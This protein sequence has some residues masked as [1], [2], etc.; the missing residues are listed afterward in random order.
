MFRILSVLFATLWLVSCSQPKPLNVGVHP[1]IGYQPIIIAQQKNR[2]PEHIALLNNQTALDTKQQFL[3][4]RI[5]AGYLT[6]DEMLQLNEQGLHLT[7]VLVTNIS[8]GA[9]KVIAR[10]PA[11]TRTTLKGQ[12]IGYEKGTVGELM[13]HSFLNHMQLTLEE[14]VPQA[15]SMDKQIQAWRNHEIDYLISYDPIAN[16]IINQHGGHKVFSSQQIP[17]TIIDVLAAR[18]SLIDQDLDSVKALTAA[19]FQGLELIKHDFQETSYLM[20]DNLGI[21]QQEVISTMG[22]LTLPSQAINREMLSNGFFEKTQHIAKIMVQAGLIQSVPKY[23][24]H[25]DRCL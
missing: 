21:P 22:E 6:L 11:L 25:T 1:W 19:H 9:D 4:G 12:R 23:P 2:L 3:D 20:A 7:V 15:I 14:V 8:S 5:D 17:D 24:I 18:Q 16:T 10:Q 13:L